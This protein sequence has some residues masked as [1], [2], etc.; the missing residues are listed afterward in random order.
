MKNGSSCLL[1]FGVAMGDD[2]SVLVESIDMFDLAELVDVFDF[3]CIWNFHIYYIN[4]QGKKNN[5]L[6][7]DYTQLSNG[8][9]SINLSIIF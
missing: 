1:L 2:G 4:K 9:Y 6:D 8:N 5:W 7:I 3:T